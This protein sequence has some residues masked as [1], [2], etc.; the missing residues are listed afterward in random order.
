MYVCAIA[1]GAVLQ[2]L[3]DYRVVNFYRYVQ[4]RKKQKLETEI[5]LLLKSEKVIFFKVSLLFII[6]INLI[7]KI[8]NS[9]R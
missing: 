1:L 7:T 3:I 6:I 8:P 2:L 4:K 5:F 9:A